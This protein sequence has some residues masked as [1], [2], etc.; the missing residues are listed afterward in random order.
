MTAVIN[1]PFVTAAVAQPTPAPA[2][3]AIPAAPKPVMSMSGQP[4]VMAPG[5]APMPAMPV[6]APMPAPVPMPQVHPALLQML[7]RIPPQAL[8]QLF[9]GMGHQQA[10]LAPLQ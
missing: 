10:P 2:M 5:P 1:N 9:G 6:P 7:S 4:Q 8:M 3:P